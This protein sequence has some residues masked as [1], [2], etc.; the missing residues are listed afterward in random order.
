M[1]EIG[2]RVEGHG[3]EEN[4]AG[5]L[6]FVREIDSQVESG[7]FEGALGTLHPV[8]DT[9]PVERGIARTTN[10]YASSVFLE[11]PING[12]HVRWMPCPALPPPV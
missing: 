9:T 3:G 8:D 7:I 5:Q 11:D 1:P 10:G 4:D 6:E 12:K 2:L